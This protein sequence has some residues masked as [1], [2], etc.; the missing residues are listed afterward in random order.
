M[1]LVSTLVVSAIALLATAC[2]AAGAAPPTSVVV[3]LRGKKYQVSGSSVKD[4]Q[5]QVAEK[6]G[7]SAEQQSVLFK[8]KLLSSDASLSSVG[9]SDGDTI[10]VVPTKRPKSERS[11]SSGGASSS[12]AVEA[13]GTV[14]AAGGGFPGAGGHGGDAWHAWHARDAQWDARPEPRGISK[15]VCSGCALVTDESWP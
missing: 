11:S 14:G 9:V 1:R 8:G 6:A 7:L 10:N 13:D 3:T 5:E 15:G 2:T 4:I 12:A